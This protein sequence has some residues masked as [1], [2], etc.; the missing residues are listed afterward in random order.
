[1]HNTWKKILALC[2]SVL[3]LA[4]CFA[5][6]GNTQ[7][8]KETTEPVVTE[9]PEEAKTLKV[10][11]I[12]HS[13]STDAGR[14]LTLIAAAEGYQDLKLG[15]LYYSGCSLPSHVKF[16]TEN[17][18]EYVL[19]LSSTTTADQPPEGIQ[20]VTMGDAVRYDYW[21]IIILQG[22]VFE[23]AEDATYKTG[24]IQLIQEFVNKN[25]KN[26]NAVFFWNVGWA[27]PTDND[28]RDTYTMQ[29]NPYYRDYAK[30]N[31]DRATMYNA[32]AQC[33]KDNILPDE[34]FKGLIPSATV[35]QNALSSYLTEK[36][37]YRDYAHATDLA[38]VMVSY[39]WFCKLTG[40]EHLDEIKLDAVPK[41]FFHTT[42]LP[43]DWELTEQEKALILETVNNTLAN[44]LQMTQSTFTEA[45]AQ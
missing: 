27:F 21:D 17:S 23:I 1:M 5:A 6:C 2:L 32:I 12:G 10:L 11:T 14:M 43:V 26:P 39:L 42:K 19:Y 4:G 38:C 25:K 33:V 34:T 8:Q 28:L 40:V 9:P 13:L 16:M 41:R 29:P 7:E 31:D 44:P 3:M 36:D 22:G 35:M 15:T 45:P 18:R 37:V 20:S 24:N 30:F